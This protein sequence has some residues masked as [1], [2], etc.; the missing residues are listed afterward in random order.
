MRYD[1]YAGQII[2]LIIG[3]T[4]IQK[5]EVTLNAAQDTDKYHLLAYVS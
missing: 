1:T 5:A 4:M 3:A 2:M